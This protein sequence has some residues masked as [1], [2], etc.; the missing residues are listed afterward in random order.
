MWIARLYKQTSRSATASPHRTVVSCA[1]GAQLPRAAFPGTLCGW[2]GSGPGSRG[3]AE[4]SSLTAGRPSAHVVRLHGHLCAELRF[5]PLALQPGP[6][7]GRAGDGAVGALPASVV[8]AVATPAP[9][10]GLP[11]GVRWAPD[12]AE[13]TAGARSLVRSRGALPRPSLPVAAGATLVL[14]ALRG[15]AGQGSRGHLG[16][17]SAF[18]CLA[19]LL[20]PRTLESN[21]SSG[22]E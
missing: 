21:P 22:I 6:G 20:L 10:A 1:V 11:E 17:E 18:R 9:G 15:R 19:V 12:R 4:R 7:S 3:R 14:W 8:A 5:R 16:A 2:P 13:P